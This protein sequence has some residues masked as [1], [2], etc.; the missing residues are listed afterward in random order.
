MCS[1]FHLADDEISDE[2]GRAV[3]L[4]YFHECVMSSLPSDP[5]KVPPFYAYFVD[6]VER[7][8]SMRMQDLTSKSI[9]VAASIQS[10]RSR[11]NRESAPS[12]AL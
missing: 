9:R 11:G 5:G 6:I 3:L 7:L 12:A 10:F 4:R 2:Y 8:K 1:Y